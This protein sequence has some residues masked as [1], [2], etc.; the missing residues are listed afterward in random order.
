VT[1]PLAL[2]LALAAACEDTSYRDIGAEITVLTE[3]TD[4]LVPLARRRLVAFRRRAIPQIE[5]ALHTA[6]PSGKANLLATLD[7]IADPEAAPIL[8]HL[9]LY[10]PEPPVRAACEEI[11]TR[12]SRRPDLAAAATRALSRIADKRARGEGPPA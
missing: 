1:R 6:S 3:R 7:E 12:W 4:A 11:L 8:A 2:I 10:D 5:I 9:A